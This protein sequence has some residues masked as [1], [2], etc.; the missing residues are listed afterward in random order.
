M[1]TFMQPPKVADVSHRNGR[2]NS[3]SRSAGEKGAMSITAPSRQAIVQP[4]LELTT[5]GDSYEQEADRM[6]DFVM[7]KA[8]SGSNGMPTEHPSR[9]S[10]L[11]PV[12]SRQTDGVSSGLAIDPAT[13]SG[14]NASRGGGQPLPD[15]LRT[16]ME[17]D[18]GTDF[19]G[20]RLHTG[21]QA[22]DLNNTLQ[23]KAFTYG[24]DIFF[25][26]GQYNPQSAAGQHLIA[27]ELTHVVQQSGKVGREPEFCTKSEKNKCYMPVIYIN[28]SGRKEFLFSGAITTIPIELLDPAYFK[29]IVDPEG[30]YTTREDI[31]KQDF[32][33]AKKAVN[34]CLEYIE[35][36]KKNEEK[37]E[38]LDAYFGSANISDIE[39]VFK[40][41]QN[42]M[43]NKKVYFSH[44]ATSLNIDPN[45]TIDA[46]TIINDGKYAIALC[47]SYFSREE[48]TRVN[49]L[50]HELAH[51]VDKSID[52]LLVDNEGNV[53][54]EGGHTA[55]GES[56]VKNLAS[57]RNNEQGIALKNASNYGFFAQKMYYEDLE[58]SD[59]PTFGLVGFSIKETPSEI[60]HND[61]QF[62]PKP[63]NNKNVSFN[64][65]KKD[66]LKLPDGYYFKLIKHTSNEFIIGGEIN[67]SDLRK[68][69]FGIGLL[70]SNGS[71]FNITY[72]IEK[73]RT[74]LYF[75]IKF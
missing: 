69:T 24:N 52:D 67:L 2:N 19:S 35:R 8:F 66:I 39:N 46:Y 32:D 42:V 72:N 37:R 15:A 47:D 26:S 68:S 45:T 48:K 49:L 9:T 64:T 30:N 63:F 40:K 11:P 14:I 13:E 10:A 57:N 74:M 70:N 12:I 7:R 6:A 3:L 36:I 59:N 62:I 44:C 25:N 50:V 51:E 23:A 27:H 21:S 16:K 75:T 1:A 4:K 61:F 34:K 56:D 38:A 20:V 17:G 41:I 65:L 43:V 54:K 73:K 58:T 31:V 5:P 18:F 71:I 33:K 60:L 22:T 53:V 29:R 28:S 55:Y